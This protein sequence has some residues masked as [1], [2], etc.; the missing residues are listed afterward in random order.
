MPELSTYQYKTFGTCYLYSDIADNDELAFSRKGSYHITKQ[1][2]R[3]TPI[4]HERT[5][6]MSEAILVKLASIETELKHINRDI[7]SIPSV[8][9]NFS[10]D[11]L[12]KMD[13]TEDKIIERVEKLETLPTQVSKLSGHVNGFTAGIAIAAAAIIGIMSFILSKL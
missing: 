9:Q 3:I 2:A 13:N 11:L 6:N 1:D 12:E 7:E 8:L 10:K 4:R 5:I